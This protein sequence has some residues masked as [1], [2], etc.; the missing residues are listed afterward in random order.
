MDKIKRKPHSIETKNKIRLAHIGKKLTLEHRHKLSLAKK[1]RM[2]KNIELLKGTAGKRFWSEESR[3]KQSERNILMFKGKHHSK[4][5][6]DKI[7]MVV[8]KPLSKISRIKSSCTKRGILL[9]EFNGFASKVNLLIRATKAYSEWRL[10]IFER[11]RFMCKYCNKSKCYLHAHHLEPFA[12]IV[13]RY[14]IKNTEEAM[15][16]KELWDINNGITLCKDCHYELHKKN[17][18]IMK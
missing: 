9:N 1:G 15:N 4:E 6:H 16:C 11:D 14:R 17:K 5:W 18:I 3:K 13:N 8:H 2:P 10:K 7:K 12:E